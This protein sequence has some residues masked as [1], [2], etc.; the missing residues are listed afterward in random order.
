MKAREASD[1]AAFR[2]WL[3]RVLDL[4]LRYVECFAPYDD[5]YDVLLDDYEQGMRTDEV[6]AIFS[7]LQPELTALVAEHA[8]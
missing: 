5:P 4:R 7:V 2:P 1:F 3:E 8:I 6:R